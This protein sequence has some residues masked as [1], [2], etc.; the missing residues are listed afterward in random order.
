LA[1]PTANVPLGT[2]DQA[3]EELGR[4]MQGMHGLV[5][6][7]FSN[8]LSG[9]EPAAMPWAERS[10]T[11][12]SPLQARQL[13][14]LDTLRAEG[15]ITDDFYAARRADISPKGLQ[16]PAEEMSNLQLTFWRTLVD[17]TT[18][19]VENVAVDLVVLGNLTSTW[20]LLPVQTAVDLGQFMGHEYIWN[21]Y[22]PVGVREAP[23]LDLA[24]IGI[25]RH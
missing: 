8:G 5:G 10:A 13:D 2:P 11:R 23:V 20:A 16:A 19:L 12:L 6:L 1:L 3:L 25:V 4:W 15:L 14:T 7:G 9:I 18:T 24:Q 22:G 21:E 17:Q